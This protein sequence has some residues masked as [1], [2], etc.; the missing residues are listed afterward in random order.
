MDSKLEELLNTIKLPEE[1]YSSFFDVSLKRVK[2]SKN[3]MRIILESN[4]P[5]KLDVYL[6]LN[7]LLNQFFN[8]DCIVEINTK[9]EDLTGLRDCYNYAVSFSK[10]SL[11]KDRLKNNYNSYYIE[12][13]NEN[14]LRQCSEDVDKV[15]AILVL[16]GYKKL[17]T[18][19]NEFNRN[20]VE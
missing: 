15:N 6:K 19:V 4:I 3:K 12:F 10:I 2:V 9:T 14:E 16:M 5:L 13:N 20:K 11:L 7:E 17:E 8:T 18:M 1:E